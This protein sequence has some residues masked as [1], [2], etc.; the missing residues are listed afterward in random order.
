MKIRFNNFVDFCYLQYYNKNKS[1]KWLGYECSQ[2]FGL[3]CQ[4]HYEL[5]KQSTV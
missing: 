5:Y 4:Y 2:H 1:K 3:F